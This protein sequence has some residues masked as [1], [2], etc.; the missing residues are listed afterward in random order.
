VLANRIE[1]TDARCVVVSLEARLRNAARSP[2]WQS[3]VWHRCAWC[4]RV[5][6]RN[7]TY[8]EHRDL[9]PTRVTT[10]G[11]CPACATQALARVEMRAPRAQLLQAA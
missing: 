10:D 1:A 11:M 4:G 5:A 6:D 3:D 9:S 2:D 7:G 8:V